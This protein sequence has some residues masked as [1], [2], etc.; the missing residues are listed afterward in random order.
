MQSKQ[1]Y[2]QPHRKLEAYATYLLGCTSSLRGI[3]ANFT[4]VNRPDMACKIA[5][6]KGGVVSNRALKNH[7]D[8]RVSLEPLVYCNG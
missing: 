7:T 5:G 8:G 4:T 3:L 1:R 2:S 6:F